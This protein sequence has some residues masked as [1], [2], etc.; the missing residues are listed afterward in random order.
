[1]IRRQ[2][3]GVLAIE[4]ME[5]AVRRSSDRFLARAFTAGE[6]I[7]CEGRA[8][9]LAGRWAAKEA[10]IKGF[11][12]T[13]ICYPRRRIEGLPGETGGPLV[14]LI[15]GGPPGARARGRHPD[16]AGRGRARA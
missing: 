11:D 13:P 9:R 5:R 16:R 1:M 2:G 6:L 4:R 14:R 10:G 12:R 3:I 7:Y 8:E 15:G